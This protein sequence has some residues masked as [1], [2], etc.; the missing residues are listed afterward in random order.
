MYIVFITPTDDVHTDQTVC[1]M[2]T[3]TFTSTTD[4]IISNETDNIISNATVLTRVLSFCPEDRDSRILRNVHS[5]YHTPTFT[6]TT[7]NIISK[8]TQYN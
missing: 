6:S 4:N 7:D 8:E 5:F 3:Q 1:Q 2:K